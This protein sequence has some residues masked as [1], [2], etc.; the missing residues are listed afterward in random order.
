MQHAL[1]VPLSEEANKLQKIRQ[2]RVTHDTDTLHGSTVNLR[3]RIMNQLKQ[4]WKC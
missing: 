4:L 2:S 1:T 3:I